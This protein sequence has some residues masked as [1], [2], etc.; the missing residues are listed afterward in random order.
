MG[1]EYSYCDK[2]SISGRLVKRSA[3]K[4]PYSIEKISDFIICKY[5]EAIKVDV[6]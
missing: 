2:A 5:G 6:E 1:A 3:S 4:F